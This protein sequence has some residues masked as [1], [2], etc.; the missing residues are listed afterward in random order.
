MK[1]CFFRHE[2]IKPTL[3]PGLLRSTNSPRPRV[4]GTPIALFADEPQQPVTA[5][6][7]YLRALMLEVLNTGSLNAPQIEIADEW[8]AEWTTDY[9]LDEFYSPRSHALFVDLDLMAGLQLVT[10]IS[11]KPSYPLCAYR[12]PERA[13]RGGARPASYWQPYRGRGAPIHF[14]MKEHVALLTT[15]ERLYAAL[16]RPAPRA[17][18][19]ASPSKT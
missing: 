9:A 10:S 2:P 12:R 17:L 19:H 3:W 16:C 13:G 6:S 11:A 5:L 15:I 4:A 18:R 1:W 8:L 7:L 14:S